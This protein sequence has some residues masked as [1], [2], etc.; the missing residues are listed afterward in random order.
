MTHAPNSELEEH[1]RLGALEAEI[2]DLRLQLAEAQ[3]REVR[4]RTLAVGGETVPPTAVEP[5]GDVGDA[6]ELALLRDQLRHYAAYAEAIN[7]SMGWRTVQ[8]LRTVVGRRWTAPEAS[9]AAAA[10]VDD[11]GHLRTRVDDY[12]RFVQAVEA[13]RGWRLLQRLRGLAGRRW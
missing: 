10:E 6:V 2:L 8:A 9:S 12:A 3:T 4:L 11:L 1:A 7:R 13:S 5:V